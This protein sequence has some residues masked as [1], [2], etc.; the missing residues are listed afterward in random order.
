M[1]RMGKNQIVKTSLD[2]LIIIYVIVSW[3]ISLLTIWGV[4][5]PFLFG[6]TLLIFMIVA[7]FPVVIIIRKWELRKF[8]KQKDEVGTSNDRTKNNITD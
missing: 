8:R 2:K 3:V 4:I 6:F 5:R 1:K 7:S